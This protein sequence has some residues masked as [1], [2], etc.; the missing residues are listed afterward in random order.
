[1]DNPYQPPASPAG[2]IAPGSALDWSPFAMVAWPVVLILNLATPVLFASSMTGEHG[3]LGVVA[4]VVVFLV[5]GWLACFA[6]PKLA[7]RLL[8]GS[9]ILA[10]TQI[11]PVIQIVAG[12]VAVSIGGAIGAAE[13]NEWEDPRLTSEL[14]GFVVAS[15]TGVVMA[16]VSMAVG[17]LLFAVFTSTPDLPPKIEP[18]RPAT[19]D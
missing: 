17:Y 3:K 7:N 2:E 6:R 13:V 18:L 1:M 10:V 5:I 16:G 14:G 12:S 11:F 9:A 15:I 19:S 8:A 4:A